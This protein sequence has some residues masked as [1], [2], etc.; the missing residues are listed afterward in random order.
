MTPQEALKILGHYLPLCPINIAQHNEAI[1]AL[2]LLNQIINPPP[3]E[4]PAKE[5]N[6]KKINE[7]K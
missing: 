2:N 5:N 3:A 7:K 1:A 6:V 4:E